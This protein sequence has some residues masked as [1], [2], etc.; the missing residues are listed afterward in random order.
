MSSNVERVEIYSGIRRRRRYSVA[1]KLR[2]VQEAS[3]PGIR[4]CY[5]ARQHGFFPPC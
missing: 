3:Q 5:V 2:I 4:I 1:E